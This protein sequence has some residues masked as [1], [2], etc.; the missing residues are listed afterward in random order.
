MGGVAGPLAAKCP[1]RPVDDG[2]AEGFGQGK[3]LVATFSLARGPVAEYEADSSPD[4]AVDYGFLDGGEEGA[5]AGAAACGEPAE[6]EHGAE[7]VGASLV[8]R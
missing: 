4:S 2:E 5:G 1:G 3:E 7:G 8:L 6:V